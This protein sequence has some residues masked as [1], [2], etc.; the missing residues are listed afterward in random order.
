VPDD[1]TEG[2]IQNGR[3][4]RVLGDGCPPFAGYHLDYPTRRQSS[5][6]FSLV[7]D[8]LRHRDHDAGRAGQRS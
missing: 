5:A 1:R 3:L 2:H 7:V 6:A 4:Q 8:A